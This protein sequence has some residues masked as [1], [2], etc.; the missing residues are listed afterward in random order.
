[1][2]STEVDLAAEAVSEPAVR[3]VEPDG[4][5]LVGFFSEQQTEP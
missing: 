4:T 1:V 2:A 3:I 5:T